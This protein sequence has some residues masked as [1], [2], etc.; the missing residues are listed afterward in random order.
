MSKSVAISKLHEKSAKWHLKTKPNERDYDNIYRSKL[1]SGVSSKKCTAPRLN[2]T[3][4]DSHQSRTN[5]F[6]QLRRKFSFGGQPYIA[7]L[8]HFILLNIS[9]KHKIN[10]TNSKNQNSLSRQIKVWFLV[11]FFCCGS[12]SLLVGVSEGTIALFNRSNG[13]E[14]GHRVRSDATGLSPEPSDMCVFTVSQQRRQLTL[15]V[16]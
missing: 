2:Y 6:S 9:T 8:Y 13:R 14:T 1:K 5:Q 4:K 3:V 10:N 15:V 12:S 7:Y 16:H 11:G